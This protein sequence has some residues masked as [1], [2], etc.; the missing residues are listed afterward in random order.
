MARHQQSNK[1]LIP[2][3]WYHILLDDC[4]ING[5]IIAQFICYWNDMEGEEV[6]SPNFEE[7]TIL[8]STEPETEYWDALFNIGRIG[9]YWGAWYPMHLKR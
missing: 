5:E 4:C 8:L 1:K 9:P 2:G 3:E 6:D 7:D